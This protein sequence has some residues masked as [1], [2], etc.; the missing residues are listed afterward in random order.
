[1]RPSAVESMRRADMPPGGAANGPSPAGVEE[2]PALG[3]SMTRRSCS[4][5]LPALY[6]SSLSSPTIITGS[7][8]RETSP[9]Y[10]RGTHSSRPVLLLRTSISDQVDFP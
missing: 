8:M 10:R 4:H 3:I 2:P 7:S 9:R 1:M 5:T 6:S